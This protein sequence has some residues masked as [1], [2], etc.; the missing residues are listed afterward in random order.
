MGSLGK[1]LKSVS[2][3]TWER[4]VREQQVKDPR[5]ADGLTFTAKL[6]PTLYLDVLSSQLLTWTGYQL[7]SSL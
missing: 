6:H 4:D 3:T 5:M 7:L 1:G 2:V